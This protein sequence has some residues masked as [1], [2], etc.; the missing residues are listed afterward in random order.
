MNYTEQNGLDGL[1]MLIDFKKAFDS[2]SWDFLYKVLTRFSFGPDFIQWIKVFNSNTKAT[3]LQADFLSEFINIKRGCKQGDPIAP[4]LFIICAQILFI[5]I[6]DNSNI[7]GVKVGTD[8]YKI[9]QFADD[10]TLILD[11]S[12]RSLL[13]AVNT[14][15]IFGTVSGLKMNKSKTKLI[16]IG[17]K[18]ISKEKINTNYNLEWGVTELTFLGIHFSV[19]LNNM[20]EINYPKVVNKIEKLLNGWNRRCLTPIGKIT[21]IKTL[22]V[23]QL[24]HI[25]MTC[26]TGGTKYTKELEKSFMHFCGRVNLI[27]L[28]VLI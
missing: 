20:P 27:R 21:I 18:K 28:S 22:A 23:S 25:I 16:W 4:Y 14:I 5:L 13:S 8:I 24:N 10:T 15:E 19:D 7:K 3:V 17:R 9:T 6:N 11:G 1:L 12:E 2:I 26:P